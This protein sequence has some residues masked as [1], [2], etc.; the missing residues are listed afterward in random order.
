MTF[1]SKIFTAALV[2]AVLSPTSLFVSGCSEDTPAVT[3]PPEE[4]ESELELISQVRIQV[5]EPS[6]LCFSLDKKSLWTVSDQ[7]R[8]V[9]RTDLDGT[10][11]QTL[12][13]TGNDLEGIAV[14]SAD[15]TIWVA[16][17]YLSQIV[18]LDALGN[19]LNRVTVTG[20]AGDSGLE[21]VTIDSSN[22]H[23]FLLKEQDPGVLIEL[24]ETFELLRYQ[25]IAFAFDYSGI[26]YEQQNRHLW[27]VS[28]QE[29]TVYKCDMNAQVL[30]EYPV[31][32]PK[33]EGIAV[34]IENSLVYL[35]SDS[36]EQLYVFSIRE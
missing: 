12:S 1:T 7:T 36:H 20:A 32:V 24:D 10:V 8:K 2:C 11:L 19:E 9:Y 16:E 6:G 30:A 5:D 28:D 31:E 26:F 23:F 33:A 4:R 21:G 3:D 29:K 17:E 18:Q 14:D 15:S 25:R 34:D 22:R 27:I 35:V 13:Y